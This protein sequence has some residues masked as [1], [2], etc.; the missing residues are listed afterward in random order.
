MQDEAAIE[1]AKFAR[2][3]G[4]RVYLESACYDTARFA[5]VLPYIDICKVELKLRDSKIVNEKQSTPTC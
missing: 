5:Q 4:L 3:K 1:V 2:Q